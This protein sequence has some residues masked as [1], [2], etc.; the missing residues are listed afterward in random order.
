MFQLNQLI[1]PSKTIGWQE[2]YLPT[3][4]VE[5]S[6]FVQNHK[7]LLGSS[8]SRF[9]F[10]IENVVRDQNGACERTFSE[11]QTKHAVVSRVN[12]IIRSPKNGA[13]NVI[14]AIDFH[15]G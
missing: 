14:H 4:L 3:D 9:S 12:F 5:A 1:N 6:S 15:R 8:S 11:E 10:P 7:G 2:I 13:K